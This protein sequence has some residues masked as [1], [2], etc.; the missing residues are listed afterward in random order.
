[1]SLDLTRWKQTETNATP[2]R[3]QIKP[4]KVIAY[5]QFHTMVITLGLM[6]EAHT[7]AHWTVHETLASLLADLFLFPNMVKKKGNIWLFLTIF[8]G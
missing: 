7:H 6:G 4:P 3:G 5:M 8:Q 2:L 1:M